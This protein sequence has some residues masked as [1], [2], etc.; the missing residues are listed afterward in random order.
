[1][2]RNIRNIHT[3]TDTGRA[4]PWLG[5]RRLRVAEELAVISGLSCNTP[6]SQ[7]H[8]TGGKKIYF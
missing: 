6:E 5:D 3:K 7:L 8:R 1:M 4:E 2:F